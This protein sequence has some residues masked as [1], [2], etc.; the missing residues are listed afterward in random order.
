MPAQ[1]YE[2]D[3]SPARIEMTTNSHIYGPVASRR[4]GRSLGIDLVPFK[5]CTYDCIYCQLGLTTNKTLRRREW[6]S[7]G[8]VIAELE[9]KLSTRPDYIALG[10]SGEPTLYPRID[11]IIDGVRSATNIPI[12]VLT[13]GSLLWREEVRRQLMHADLVLPSLD[14]SDR[15][16]FSVINRPH[17]DITFER[18][19]DGLVTFREEYRGEYWLEVVLLA[20]YTAIPAEVRKMADLAR[21]IKPDRIQLNTV[22]R[23]P[24]EDYAVAVDRPCLEEL[25]ELFEPRAEVIADLARAEWPAQQAT[26]CESVLQMLRRRPCDLEGIAKGLGVHRNEIVKCIRE[27]DDR[28]LLRKRQFGGKA[29]YEACR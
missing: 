26:T 9:D 29:C 17:P 5:T 14:A 3:V 8:E 13:N 10:G 12:A 6:I 23:P 27:L 28:A 16:M 20:G 21:E 4:L 1:E 18:M 24:V 25:A 7:P 2:Q 15:L 19:V 22:T 11:E